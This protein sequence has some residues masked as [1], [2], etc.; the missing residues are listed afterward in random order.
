MG[1]VPIAGQIADARDIAAAGSDVFA[2][3]PGA[4]ARLGIS[5]IAVVPGLDFLK[6]GSKA[7]K[8]SLREASEGAVDG[9][10]KAGLKRVG[11]RMSKA[12]AAR[13]SS[14]LKRLAVARQ[15]MLAR[16]QSLLLD[17]G[18][19]EATKNTIRKLRNSVQDHLQPG[20]LSGA[21]RDMHGL[22]V[23][24]SGSG[25]AWDHLREVRDVVNSIRQ[26]KKNLSRGFHNLD[27]GSPAYGKLS[28]ELDALSEMERTVNAFLE[29]K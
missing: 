21:L 2:G 6:G 5:I 28:R 27:P 20:D 14:E 9:A 15:E 12:A 17:E 24:R 4:W 22:P 23:R 19:S 1:F 26:A 25:E 13:A 29:I 3:E 7:G 18:I 8:K 10:S 16:L 11:K